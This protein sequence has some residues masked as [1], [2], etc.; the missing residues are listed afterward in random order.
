MMRIGIKRVKRITSPQPKMSRYL[1]TVQNGHRA[2]L[3]TG[4]IHHHF[5]L[6]AAADPTWS[7]LVGSGSRTH[8]A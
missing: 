1:S 5:I 6:Q 3:T 8:L 2:K 7:W 4:Y